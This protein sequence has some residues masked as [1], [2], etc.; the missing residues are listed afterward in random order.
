ML[1]SEVSQ[2]FKTYNLSKNY[3]EQLKSQLN[4]NKNKIDPSIDRSGCE[5]FADTHTWYTPPSPRVSPITNFS[6]N[7]I[8]R[9]VQSIS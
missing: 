6:K 4:V 5:V 3:C 2:K 9:S 8:R 1:K 7:E